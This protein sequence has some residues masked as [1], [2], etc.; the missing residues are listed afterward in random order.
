MTDDQLRSHYKAALSAGGEAIR[1]VC[2]S[3][4]ALQSLAD[5]T[6]SESA[7]LEVLDHAMSCSSCHRELA[8]LHAVHAARPRQVALLPRQWLA[9]AG[10]LLLLGGG[11]FLARGI[12]APPENDVTRGGGVGADQSVSV[13]APLAGAA[14]GIQALVWHAV[15]GA[16]R[17][18]V[19]VLSADGQVLFARQTA[20]TL[21]S[22]PALSAPP[23][24]WW[25]RATLVDGSERRSVMVPLQPGH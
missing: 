7:R 21:T 14:G 24:A 13:I 18:S 6:A 5:G 11:A 4:E 10:F 12:M 22:M 1:G 16:T 9:A 19:E 17:Y 25:V 2:P 8:L 15:P 20:D 23:A 3:P